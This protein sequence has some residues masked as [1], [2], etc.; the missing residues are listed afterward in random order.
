MT[1]VLL[2]NVDHHDLRVVT[3][4]GP[5]FGDAVNQ[6]PVFPTEFENVQREYPIVFR[7]DAEG[8]V[9]PLALL[10]LARDENLFL[11]AQGQWT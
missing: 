3:R 2:N 4:G 7:N 6:V 10:G 9:R 1:Q 8:V 11:D 5:E